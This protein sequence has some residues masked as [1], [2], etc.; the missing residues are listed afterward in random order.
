VLVADDSPVF[1]AAAVA[2]VEATPGFEIVATCSSGRQAVGLAGT[3][4][5]DL[6][7]VDESMT[8]ADPAGA[9][10]EIAAVSPETFVVFVSADPQPAGGTPLVDKRQ[11]SP[12]TLADLW[13]QRPVE[14]EGREPAGPV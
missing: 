5:P 4:R 14:G 3:L 2:V 1:S 8:G 13:R 11:L 9:V 12:A 10:R 6:A 7:L